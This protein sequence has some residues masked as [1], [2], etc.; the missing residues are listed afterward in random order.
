MKLAVSFLAI[1]IIATATA[2][3]A[4]TNVVK[5][6]P[7]AESWVFSLGGAGSTVTTSGGDTAFGV[8][9]GLGRTGHLLLPIEAGVRQSVS[10]NDGSTLLNTRLYN[11]WTLLSGFNKRVDLFAGGAVG[12]QYG[13]QTPSWE[14]APEAGVRLW[15]KKDVAVLARAEVPFDVDGWKYKETVR[16]FVGLSVKLP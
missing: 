14:L 16:Y 2:F 6:T 11:D 4:D 1:A 10:Y 15:L 3:A 8:D 7:S 13:N 5:A 12:L 9:L